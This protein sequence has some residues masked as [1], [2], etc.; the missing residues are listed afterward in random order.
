MLATALPV[1]KALKKQVN[2]SQ[3]QQ[4]QRSTLSLSLSLSISTAIF[5]D[6]PGLAGFIGVKDDET[7]AD[8][9]R[10]KT[11]KAPVEWSP[12]TNQHPM[13]YRPD[14]LPVTQPTV[15]KH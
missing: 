6:E 15:S 12:P 4:K 3:S 13:F 9:W 2:R 8:N 11:S 7:G 1:A 10:Y 5:P 14:A